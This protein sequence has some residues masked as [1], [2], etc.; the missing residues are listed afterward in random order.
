M[1]DIAEGQRNITAY[2]ARIGNG[3]HVLC[4]VCSS[5]IHFVRTTAGKQMPCQLDLECGDGKKTLVTH[6]GRT[7]C[8]AGSDVFGYQP[9]WGFCKR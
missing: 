2:Q 1:H 7:V 4:P 5:Q 8:K 9:H 3:P 6:S